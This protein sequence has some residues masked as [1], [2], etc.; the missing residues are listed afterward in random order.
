M[1]KMYFKMRIV[2]EL[3]QSENSLFQKQNNLIMQLL[4]LNFLTFYCSHFEMVVRRSTLKF[5]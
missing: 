5:F 4:T 1:R 2:Y 3:V